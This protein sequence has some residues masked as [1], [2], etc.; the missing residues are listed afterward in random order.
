MPWA[1]LRD[2]E[3]YFTTDFARE[4]KN[5]IGEIGGLKG[6]AELLGFEYKVVKLNGRSLRVMKT[7]LDKL[8]EF[9]SF[10]QN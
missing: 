8:V 6:I 5:V 10:T 7:T 2:G 4:L 3:V 1:I 9:L